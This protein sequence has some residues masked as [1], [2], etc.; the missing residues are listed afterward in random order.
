MVDAKI[1]ITTQIQLRE[2]VHLTWTFYLL[3]YGDSKSII[4][5]LA[6]MGLYY[7]DAMNSLLSI[8]EKKDVHLE[9]LQEKL[10]DLGGSYF[11]RKYR[12]LLDFFEVEKWRDELREGVRGEGKLSGWQLFRRWGEVDEEGRL[13][14]EAGIQALGG[15][16]EEKQENEK[17]EREAIEVRFGEE[18][19]SKPA[20]RRKQDDSAEEDF[21]VYYLKVDVLTTGSTDSGKEKES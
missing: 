20:K 5:P 3:P 8:I 15:W 7:Y 14:W 6:R 13:D 11:P 21:A 18:D 12:G 19:A 4:L 10:K 17:S 2:R 1:N 9:A 16:T